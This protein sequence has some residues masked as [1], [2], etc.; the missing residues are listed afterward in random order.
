[1]TDEEGLIRAVLASPGDWTVRRVYA[2]WLEERGDPRAEYLRLLC[3]L[4]EW[5]SDPYARLRDLYPTIDPEWVELMHRGI[6]R[7]GL[8]HE[9]AY[10]SHCQLVLAGGRGVTLRALH[11]WH[12]YWGLLEGLPNQSMND[13]LIRRAVE[14][15]Q[16]RGQGRQPYLI[17][18]P[19]RDYSQ[20]PGDMAAI[21]A[22]TGRAPEWLPAVTC[23]AT[24]TEVWSE[25]TVV[26]FQDEYAPPIREPA[27]GELR[28]LDWGA[29]ATHF[30]EDDL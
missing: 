13:H 26:W 4:A 22:R 27:L 29:L 24:L 15:G 21:A 30:T 17:T 23:V 5:G 18:P 16:Q 12:T 6:A 25:L 28:K 10:Y 19:R 14:E 1:M 8:E 2:D 3:S 9:P 11:Q 20:R 7:A